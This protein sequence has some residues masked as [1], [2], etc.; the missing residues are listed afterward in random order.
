ML[1]PQ[2]IPN[3]SL[4]PS[5]AVDLATRDGTPFAR[6][7]F[8][9]FFYSIHVL[10]LVTEV[11]DRMKKKSYIL[12]IHIHCICVLSE[13]VAMR[14]TEASCMFRIHTFIHTYIHTYTFIHMNTCITKEEKK[15]HV[16]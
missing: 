3:I 5:M 15:K 13:H 12:P 14:L 2:D 16:I 10:T 8:D 9:V 7:I 6:S 11:Y 4:F 1:F